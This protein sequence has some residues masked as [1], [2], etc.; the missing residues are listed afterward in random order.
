MREAGRRAARRA[1]IFEVRELENDV[2]FLRNYLTEDLVEELD[3][4]LYRREGDKWVDRRERLG[5]GSRS[6]WSAA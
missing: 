5:A 2:S 4:Y 1:K 6:S 3:L